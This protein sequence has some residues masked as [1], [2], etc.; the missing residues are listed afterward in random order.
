MLH[1]NI[2]LTLNIM[3]IKAAGSLSMYLR[4][5]KSYLW[6]AESKIL[7]FMVSEVQ[8]IGDLCLKAYRY[9]GLKSN[10]KY[11]STLYFK[12]LLKYFLKCFISK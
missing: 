4:F 3:K 10:Y 11:T 8:K 5:K 1:N 6:S 7:N 9:Y 2:L 12:I